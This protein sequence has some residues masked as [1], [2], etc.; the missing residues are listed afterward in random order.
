MRVMEQVIVNHLMTIL[1]RMRFLNLFQRNSERASISREL[2]K[3]RKRKLQKPRSSQRSLNVSLCLAWVLR[4]ITMPRALETLLF[5]QLPRKS[6]SLLSNQSPGNWEMVESKE[7][8]VHTLDIKEMAKI[9]HSWKWI[10]SGQLDV[11][12]ARSFIQGSRATSSLKTRIWCTDPQ[13]L[14]QRSKGSWA[15]PQQTRVLPTSWRASIKNT[16]KLLM[17]LEAK[18]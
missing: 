10:F 12:G 18:V 17:D 3:R 1:I 9:C 14:I 4:R 6:L 11:S 2:K 7:M 5:Q 15:N 13:W 8:S 16:A